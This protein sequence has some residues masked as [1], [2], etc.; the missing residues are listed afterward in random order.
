MILSTGASSL[1]EIFRAVEL[2]RQEGNR[3]ISLLHCVLSYPCQPKDANLRVISTLRRLFPECVIG[4]SDH[5]PP[6]HGGLCLTTAWLQ[7]ALILEKHFTL[8]KSK[9]GNDHYHAFDAADLTEFRARCAYITDLLG[10]ADKE[11]LACEAGARQ[12]ARRSLV[13]RQAIRRGETILANMIVAKRPGTGISP[14]HLSLVLGSCPNRDVEE[15]EILTWDV[16]L[17]RSAS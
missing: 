10:E 4:Y 9:P 17:T 14:E 7:G 12:N 2:I 3:Q 16:L 11:L 15:D 6:L 13:A 5:V 8:D 1:S